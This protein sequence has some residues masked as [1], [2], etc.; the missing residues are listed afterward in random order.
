MQF[1]PIRTRF[2][3]LSLATALVLAPGCARTVQDVT[4]PSAA[5][6]AN[7]ELDPNA[8]VFGDV[9]VAQNRAGGFYP[10]A[11]GNH[12]TYD[13]SFSVDTGDPATTTTVHSTNEHELLC[14]EIS[15][16][17]RYV[18]ELQRSVS[19]Q[20]PSEFWVVYRQDARGLYEVDGAGPLFSCGVS[21]IRL[22]AEGTPA[23]DPFRSLAERNWAMRKPTASLARERW[24]QREWTRQVNLHQQI[25]AALGLAP[26]QRPSPG[27]PGGVLPGEITRLLYPMHVGQQWTIRADPLFTSR[28]VARQRVN[29]PAGTVDAYKIQITSDLF[30]PDDRVYTWYGRVGYV[31]LIA[32]LKSVGADETGNP[33]A[34]ISEQREILTSFE[35]QR[36]LAAAETPASDSYSRTT[37]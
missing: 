18:A 30:G 36:A 20:G 12:W 10:L 33:T 14:S 28:V 19:D 4:G 17:N 35:L 24:L 2:A 15:E 37:R 11:V 1:L 7:L 16:S 32:N 31:G 21:P 8:L 26:G 27:P 3:V 6:V 25:R 9:S 22:G 13:A 23:V 5:T 34:V 29:T